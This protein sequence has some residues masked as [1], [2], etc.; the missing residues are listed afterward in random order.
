MEYAQLVVD[1]SREEELFRVL[2]DTPRVAA[3]MSRKAAVDTFYKTMAE[4]LMVFVSFFSAFAVALGFGVVYNSA[5]IALSERGRDLAT[6]RVLGFTRQEIAY[7]LLGEVGLL[8]FVAL[9]LGCVAGRLLAWMMT[10][11]FETELFRIPLV[12]EST[13][14]GI[15]ILTVLAS[16][17]VSAGLVRHQVNNLDLI[18]VLKT[19]E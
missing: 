3:V 11:I 12:L 5:R 8:I 19:R 7:I 1:E 13:T 9:P 6:L 10:S 15:A 17:A 2:K 14:Y 4:S 18:G 16:A